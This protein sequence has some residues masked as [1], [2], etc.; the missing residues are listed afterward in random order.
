M[1]ARLKARGL[2]ICLRICLRI[3]P[4]IAQQSALFDEGKARGY[5]L[6]RHAGDVWQTDQ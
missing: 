6:R 2:R 3:N 4:Y 1:L 5:L